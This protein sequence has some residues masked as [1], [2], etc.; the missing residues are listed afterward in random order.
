MARRE[1]HV[2]LAER[3]LGG[4]GRILDK[5]RSPETKWGHPALA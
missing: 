4:L 5:R 1:S 3:L 2:G